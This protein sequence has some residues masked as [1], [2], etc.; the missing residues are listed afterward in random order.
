M[1]INSSSHRSHRRSS[2]RKK[3][4]TKLSE[5]ITTDVLFKFVRKH[6]KLS[7]A[8]GVVITSLLSLYVFMHLIASSGGE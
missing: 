8:V 3:R 6:K 1:S 5:E 4:H 7:M 2:R